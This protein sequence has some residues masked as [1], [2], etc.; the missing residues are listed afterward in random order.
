[1]PNIPV[2]LSKSEFIQTVMDFIGP[3]MNGEAGFSTKNPK[4]SDNRGPNG[5]VDLQERMENIPWR[6]RL[7]RV[8]GLRI[9]AGAAKGHAHL[10]SSALCPLLA[11]GDF[12]SFAALP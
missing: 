12:G 4:I 9:T 8:A 6:Y 7:E 10:S 2:F 5:H 11:H 3:K 1:M